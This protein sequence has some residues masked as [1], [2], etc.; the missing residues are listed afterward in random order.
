MS[1]ERRGRT[2]QWQEYYELHPEVLASWGEQNGRLPP[3]E[4]HCEVL[5]SLEFCWCAAFCAY[6][7]HH[8]DSHRYGAETPVPCEECP[9]G[10]CAR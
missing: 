7:G 9:E 3:H 8:A 4:S 1:A 5:G 10:A 6:C 2:P